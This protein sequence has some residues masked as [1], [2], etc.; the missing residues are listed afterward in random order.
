MFQ[1]GAPLGPPRR[2]APRSVERAASLREVL[3][4]RRALIF[5]GIWLATNVVFGAGARVLGAS[6]APVAWIA[7]IGGFVGG[8]ALFPLF[9]G[10]GRRFDE[11]AALGDA[12]RT[13]GVT[14]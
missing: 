13:W 6:D 14:P 3:T 4:D 2:G 1:P 12:S 7:H 5:I 8:L 11:C 10:A 9:D